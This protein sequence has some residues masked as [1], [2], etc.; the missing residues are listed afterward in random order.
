ME[1]STNSLPTPEYSNFSNN[2]T[3]P[4]SKYS[5]ID[6]KDNIGPP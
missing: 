4:R 1:H 3:K 2:P 5:K 6:S